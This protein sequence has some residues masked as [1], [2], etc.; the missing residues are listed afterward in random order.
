MGQLFE[1]KIPFLNI[2]VPVS[3]FTTQGFS[4]GLSGLTLEIGEAEF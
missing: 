4:K 3:F 2:G 1:N